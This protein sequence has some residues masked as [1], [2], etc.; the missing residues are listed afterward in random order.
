MLPETP[1]ALPKP[2]KLAAPPLPPAQKATN[3]CYESFSATSAEPPCVLTTASF[4]PESTSRAFLKAVLGKL[5]EETA[6]AGGYCGC[7]I[8]AT[9]Y[10]GVV[11]VYLKS[12]LLLNR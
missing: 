3:R 10:H 12:A 11:R 9:D 4:V 8:L 1:G 2:A 6:E 7:M 5:S